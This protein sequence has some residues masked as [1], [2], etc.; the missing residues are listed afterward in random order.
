MK[1]RKL[2]STGMDVSI[3]AYGASPLGN[4]FGETDE[5]EGVRAVH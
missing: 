3:L 5:A 1:Y 4:V 2:G